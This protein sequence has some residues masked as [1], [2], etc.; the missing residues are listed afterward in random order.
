[1]Y[2]SETENIARS[3]SFCEKT[4]II[5][6]INNV[7]NVMQ[8]QRFAP[9]T[10]ECE[11]ISEN[12]TALYVKEYKKA[13]FKRRIYHSFILHSTIYVFQTISHMQK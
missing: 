12:A 10:D 7:K 4:G 11:D 5:T 3:R 1:M 2:H 13:Y 6:F 9:I 8:I